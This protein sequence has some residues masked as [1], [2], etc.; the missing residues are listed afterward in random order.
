MRSRPYALPCMSLACLLSVTALADEPAPDTLLDRIVVSATKLSAR[1]AAGSVHVITETELAE[2]ASA[3][4]HRVLRQ[5][6][7][8]NL[9]EEEGF[10]IRP[11]IGIRGSGTD[12]NAKIAVL[13]DGVPIAPAPYSAPSAYY[14]PRVTRMSSVE[15]SKGPAA[16][17][18]GPQTVAGAIGMTS[19][20]IPG[21]LGEGLAGRIE[22]YGGEFDTLRGHAVAGGWMELDGER[23]LGLSLELLREESS[24]FKQL[25]SGGGTGFRIE[26][27]VAKAALRGLAADGPAQSLELKLQRSTEDSD[28]TYLGLSRGDFLASP[29][30]RYRAS[31]LDHIDVTHEL[32]Q[33][34]HRVDFSDA[35][36]LTT[37]AYHTR[38]ERAWYKLN[39]VRNAA[40]TS[41]VSLTSILSAPETRPVEFAALLGAP[42]TATAAGAL[43]MRNNQRDYQAAGIQS[44]LGLKLTTGVVDHDLELSVRWHHD[45]EDRY[46]HDDRYQMVNGTMVL[47]SAGAPGS[48]DNRIGEAAAWAFY[49]RDTMQVGRWTLAPGVRYETIRLT[50]RNWGTSDPDR[51]GRPNPARNSVATL[52]PGLGITRALGDSLLLVAGAHR[53]FVS[54]APGSTV[55]PELSWNFELGLRFNGALGGAEAMAFLVDYSNLIGTCTA[56]TGGGCTIGDQYDGG[57]VHVHGLEV[58]AHIDA[59]TLFELPVSIPLAAS[60]TWTQG[61]FRTSFASGFT[62]WGTVAAGDDLPYVPEHQLALHAGLGGAR[63]RL[64]LAANFV[65]TARAR[66]GSGPVPLMERVDSRTLVDLSGDFDVSPGLSLFASVQN[67][68]GE[69]YN[70]ALRPAGWRPGAPRTMMAGVRLRF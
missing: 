33:L 54:P 11:N 42:G 36:D 63:W 68:T 5:V 70:V 45:E 24:G 55:D 48:Q 43:R 34:T 38:T 62:E 28:E 29:Y 40:N 47:T 13:E 22:L 18:Y 1:E 23:D 39:D 9:V 66:A 2:L 30:R 46:Q 37:I 12:R 52:L 49:L 16:I 59:G 6:P 21:A 31:Q 26:D 8:L 20:P 51:T 64:N 61:E 50:Q 10:G 25:D 56:S 27:Y 35:L 4:I 57:K 67:L 7:G 58:L 41:F 32:A 17:K 69:V 3:D 19:T 44:V 60:Y 14:F 53:G 65:S 15:V